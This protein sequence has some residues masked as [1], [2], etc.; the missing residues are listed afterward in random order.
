L[1]DLVADTHAAIWYLADSKDL[2]PRA[3]AAMDEAA[4]AG[5]TV[6]VPSVSI[7]ELIYL[8]EKASCRRVLWIGCWPL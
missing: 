8:I 5:D 7:V 3:A 4:E 2:S 6:Y 1:S